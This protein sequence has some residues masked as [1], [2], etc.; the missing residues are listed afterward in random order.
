MTDLQEPSQ[1]ESLPIWY[2]LFML[3]GAAVIVIVAWGVH[4]K[5]GQNAWRLGT[6]ALL[7]YVLLSGIVWRVADWLRLAAMPSAF[8]LDRVPRHLDAEGL[9]GRGTAVLQI[10]V[11][12]LGKR[13][14]SRPLGKSAQGRSRQRDAYANSNRCFTY[15]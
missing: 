9:L 11:P 13:V 1:S 10:V 4:L 6:I 2:W 15:G 7:G 3:A 12:V 5:G 8:F 14:C